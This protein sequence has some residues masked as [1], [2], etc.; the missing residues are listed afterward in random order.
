MLL[1]NFIRG[2]LLIIWNVGSRIVCFPF[3]IL[4]CIVGAICIG[5]GA[6]FDDFKWAE[7]FMD[8]YG[9]SLEK[10]Y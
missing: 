4:L 1:T 3:I 5:G 2:L 10:F 6:T 9:G 7:K 8:W